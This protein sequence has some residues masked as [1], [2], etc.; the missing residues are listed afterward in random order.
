MKHTN[1]DYSDNMNFD[2]ESELLELR[3]LS[4]DTQAQLRGGALFCAETNGCGLQ[5][6]ESGD[7]I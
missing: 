5:Q 3:S 2:L 4:H 6:T 1:N 7:G